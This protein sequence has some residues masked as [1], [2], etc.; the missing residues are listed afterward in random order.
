MKE[1]DL[2]ERIKQ[3][4]DESRK[5]F[6]ERTTIVL[7]PCCGKCGAFVGKVERTTYYKHQDIGGGRIHRAILGGPIKPE[8]CPSCGARFTY[9]C[10][11]SDYVIEH[12]EE[13]EDN[14]EIEDN[15]MG[16]EKET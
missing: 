2:K 6:G 1:V 5:E 16:D 3:L 13:K 4:E 15:M 10:H 8:S 9:V 14:E 12:F 11:G 7:K